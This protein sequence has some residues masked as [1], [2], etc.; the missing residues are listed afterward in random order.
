MEAT[1]SQNKN[2]GTRARS[3]STRVIKSSNPQGG[4]I[5]EPSRCFVLC[6][7]LL[8]VSDS[9]GM[10]IAIVVLTPDYVNTTRGLCFSIVTNSYGCLSPPLPLQG[11]QNASNVV[12][13][14]VCLTAAPGTERTSSLSHKQWTDLL[15]RQFLRRLSAHKCPSNWSQSFPLED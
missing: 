3:N 14:P 5:P 6:L 8:Q 1:G 11:P 7:F 9:R 4:F 13:P 15:N 12:H 10:D 2:G